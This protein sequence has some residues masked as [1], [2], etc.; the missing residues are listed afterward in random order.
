MAHIKIYKTKWNNAWAV[1]LKVE[2][3][4]PVEKEAELSPAPVWTLW[5][6]E[7]TLT[8]VASR[9]TIRLSFGLQ[10]SHCSERAIP[11]HIPL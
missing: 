8:A 9:N 3:S 7:K 6:T 4:L 5:K 11:A 10:Y 1:T 2:P